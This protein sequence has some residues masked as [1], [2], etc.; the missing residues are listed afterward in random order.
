M[1]KKPKHITDRGARMVRSAGDAVDDA[2]GDSGSNVAGPSSNPA[3]NLLISDLILRSVGRIARQAVEKGLLK[4]RY[5]SD[6]AKKAVE[7]R[8]LLNTLA[9]YGATKVATRSVPGALTVGGGLLLKTL[10]DRSH[11]RRR[12]RRSGDKMVK[13]QADEDGAL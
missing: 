1:A 8:S 12:A 4:R 7:N 9:T 10:W 6:L 3:T 11:S 13:L 5:G 2:T